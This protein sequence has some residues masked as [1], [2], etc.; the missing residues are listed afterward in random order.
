MSKKNTAPVTEVSE[1]NAAEATA[2]AKSAKPNDFGFL[3]K[4]APW[5]ILAASAVIALIASIVSFYKVPTTPHVS[6]RVQFAFDGAAD[7][8]GP[9]GYAFDANEIASETVLANALKASSLSDRYTPEQVRASLVIAGV[10]PDD[11]VSQTMSYES[12]MNFTPNR[13]LNVDTFHPTLFDVS[14]YNSFDRN[15]SAKDLQKLLD[16][17][18]ISYRD[19]CATIYAHIIKNELIFTLENYDYPQQLEILEQRLRVIAAYASEMYDA[20]PAFRKNDMGFSDI[21]VRLNSLIDNDINRLNARITINALTKDSERL[22][23]QYQFEIRDLENQYNK[24]AEQLAKLDALIESYQK[25]EII[26]I[27]DGENLTKIDGNSSET[28]DR[29]VALRQ[30]VSDRNSQIRSQIA[31]YKIK[32]DDLLPEDKKTQNT[33]ADPGNTTDPAGTTDPSG[34]P[35]NGAGENN[36]GDN[37]AANNNDGNNDTTNDAADNNGNTNVDDDAAA[38]SD[39]ADEPGDKTSSISDMSPEAIAKAADDAQKRIAEQREALDRDINKLVADSD[40][41]IA[42]FTVLLDAADAQKINESTVAITDST[43]YRQKLA[44]LGFIKK[45]ILTGGPIVVVGFLFLAICMIIRKR[46]VFK[47][48]Q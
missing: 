14:L 24:H 23:T 6:A 32:L 17:I 33:P 47:A 29:L 22:L 38:D 42:D 4:N 7:G 25:N 30:S 28:Y 36:T 3:R 10:F 18:L 41:V 44:S 26:Y 35:D 39:I 48:E 12:L 45:C 1:N 19:Y 40:A 15:I 46:R 5:L 31:T 43:F 16:N 2:T 8:I 37:G 13:T 9:N 20:N 21:V 34:N 11:I 27:S